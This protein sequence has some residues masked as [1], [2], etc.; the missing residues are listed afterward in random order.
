MI[1]YVDVFM[2]GHYSD[3]AVAAT[4]V[5]SQILVISIIMYGFI[6]VGVQILVAQM[7]GAERHK[8]I[9]RVITN[10]LIVAFIIGIIMS[11][12]FLFASDTFLRLVGL[13]DELIRVGSPF[14]EIIGGSSIVIAIHS[15]ILPIIRVHGYVRQ[16]MLV[17]VT[18]SIINVVGN[19]V[20]LY[21]PLAYL[22]LGV[23]GV[24]IAT[25]IANFIGMIMAIFML[26]KYIGYTFN[27][28][29]LKH[30]S[31]KLLYSILK[32][33]LPSAGENMSYAAPS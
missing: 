33:G 21:G 22:D 19:Y 12:I 13:D 11:I 7:I 27:F 16:A 6:S 29:K 17:P 26:K 10:G 5:A 28:G 8:M 30:Y 32:L 23:A 2:L 25:A 9:E 3:E 15:S 4:G 14:L 18:I 1:N 31:N 24:G 20:F